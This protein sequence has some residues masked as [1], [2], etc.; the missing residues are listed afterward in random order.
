M[1]SPAIV[2]EGRKEGKLL[3]QYINIFK[4]LSNFFR[5]VLNASLPV[6]QYAVSSVFS[7][8]WTYVSNL[9]VR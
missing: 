3:I 7:V 1:E 9:D 8:T 2:M 6:K 5:N 4:I